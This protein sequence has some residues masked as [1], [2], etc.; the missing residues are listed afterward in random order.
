MAADPF[1]HPALFYRGCDEYVTGIVPFIAEG[2]AKGEPVAVAVP[3]SR[4]EL[5]RASLGADAARVHMA[6]M[7]EA[8][9]NPG[10]I[11]PGVLRAFADRYRGHV[12]IVGEPIWPDRSV[13]EYPACAQ[14]EALINRAFAGRR[15]TIL[16]PY[17][18]EGLSPTVLAD[19]LRTHPSVIDTDGQHTSTMFAPDSVV[20]TYNQPLPAPSNAR[21]RM[22]DSSSLTDLRQFVTKFAA[23][24]G[25]D[26]ARTGDLVLA[27]DELAANSARHGG[28]TG[29]VYLWTEPDDVVCQISDAGY[30]RD[31]L[32]GRV[33]A[34]ADQLG[35]RGLLLVNHLADLVRT[36]STPAGTT[37]RIHFRR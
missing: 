11:I 7:T 22:A 13:V 9:R 26:S 27:V 21:C 32:I 35:G 33:P 24:S 20:A 2:L 1:A 4:L 23:Q 19:A 34:P 12:R 10:R 8:G 3:G 36:H 37:I 6:D 5:L 15:A 14:H 30:L 29:V 25:L 31:P 28:G 17:D 18:T 16:C